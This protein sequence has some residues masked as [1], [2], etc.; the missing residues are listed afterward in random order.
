MIHVA[1]LKDTLDSSVHSQVKLLCVRSCIINYSGIDNQVMYLIT[2]SY[3]MPIVSRH[4][5]NMSTYVVLCYVFVIAI[6]LFYPILFCFIL[7]YLVC[8]LRCI[9]SYVSDKTKTDVCNN[10]VRT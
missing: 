3:M 8:A 1:V 4:Y 2:T 5:Y 6:I 10:H 7:F 9:R